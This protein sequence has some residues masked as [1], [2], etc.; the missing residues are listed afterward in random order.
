MPPAATEY[1]LEV[2][3][4]DPRRDR[5]Q[6]VDLYRSCFPGEGWTADDFA[7]FADKLPARNGPA[8]T[9]FVK[10]LVD[11]GEAVYG[12]LLYTLTR[13]ECRIRRLAVRPDKRRL[14]FGTFMLAAML[15]GLNGRR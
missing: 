13:K 3:W 15:W 9:N 5:D 8:R 7:A 14:G 12:S 2:R 1:R 6:V 4:Y 11:R 10:V